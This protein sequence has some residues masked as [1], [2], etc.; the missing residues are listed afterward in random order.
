[1]H[2]SLLN[3]DGFLFDLDGTVYLGE[4]A[5][6]GAVAAIAELRQRGKKVL[7]VSNKPLEPRA[8]Y[9]QKLTRLGIPTE[10]AHV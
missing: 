6:P 4:S 7:F 2:H 5:I 8:S 1:M 9:A 10:P 3:I